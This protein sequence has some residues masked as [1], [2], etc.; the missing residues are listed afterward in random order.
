MKDPFFKTTNK[1]TEKLLKNKYPVYYEKIMTLVK[2]DNISIS[3]R[4]FL[5]QNGLFEAPKCKFCNL[6]KVAFIK[7]YKGYATYCSRSCA[8]KSTHLDPEV[9]RKRISS[10]QICNTDPEIRKRM[11]ERANLTKLNFDKSRIEKSNEKR[12]KTNIEKYGVGNISQNPDVKK[13]IKEKVSVAMNQILMKKSI[14][15]IEQSGFKINSIDKDIFNINC[16][17]CGND[18]SIKRSL[19]NQRKRFNI[20]ICLSCNPISNRSDFENNILK[21]VQEIYGGK[22]ENNKKFGK[23]YEIDIYIPELKIGI[24]CNGLWWHSEIYRDKNYHIDKVKFFKDKNIDIINIWEDDWRYKGHIVKSRLKNRIAKVNKIYA[25]N[26]ILKEVSK[27]E[28]ID[29]LNKN[30][31]QG[32]C[33]SKYNIGLYYNDKL[34][35]ILTLGSLRKNLGHIS[36]NGQYEILRSCSL[37]EYSI[38]GGFSKCLS[39]FKVN[40]NPSRIISYCDRSFNTGNSYL[41]NGFQLIKTT[42]PNY[43]WFNKDEGIRVNRWNYR[44]DKLVKCGFDTNKTE[45]QIMNSQGYYRIWDCGSFLFEMKF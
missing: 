27:S 9:K 14:L 6:N 29:F 41:K 17:F 26:C 7:F 12:N 5:Y 21:Y 20:T 33:I 8:A 22:I 15:N 44:K 23:N 28:T 11:T 10:I 40:Y 36:T 13:K 39:Y 25:R 32:Y 2:E 42:L 37:I 18:I 30:H 3:E 24:E 34:V 35:Y 16:N 45:I 4:I 38:V 31:I 19:F 1:V 43:Y